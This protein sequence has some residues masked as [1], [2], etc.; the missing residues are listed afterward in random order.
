MNFPPSMNEKK[1]YYRF[2]SYTNPKLSYVLC[3]TLKC[4]KQHIDAT[5]KSLFTN[6]DPRTIDVVY[7]KENNLAAE[8]SELR[9]H[10]IYYA[11]FKK[12]IGKL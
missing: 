9:S 2:K 4:T 3:C 5:L 6:E 1:F 10:H 11:L 7:L 8:F 12:K